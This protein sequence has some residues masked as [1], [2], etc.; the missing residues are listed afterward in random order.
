VATFNTTPNGG[1][2]GIWQGGAGPVFDVAGKIYAVTGNG[3]FRTDANG[4]KNYG[5][6]ILKLPP[7]PGGDGILPVLD[8]FTSFEQA[9]L[10]QGDIDQGSGGI[11]LLPDQAG[12]HTHLLVQTGKRGKIY[13]L[14][15][16]NL[17]GYR[18]GVVGCDQEPVLETCDKAVQFTPNGTVGGGSYGTSAYFNTGSAQ[19]IYYGGNGDTIKALQFNAAM[20]N[21]DLPPIS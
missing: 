5:E 15:R 10:N 9:A 3:T 7:T 17:G 19:F 8:S 4:T 14:D 6:T 21:I 18:H 20:G 12:P 13:L 16:D 11:L 1:L 2:G